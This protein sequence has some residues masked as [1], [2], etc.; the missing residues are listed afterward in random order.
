[1]T[2][3]AILVLVDHAMIMRHGYGNWALYTVGFEQ[4]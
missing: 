2:D 4:I 1:M 3:L